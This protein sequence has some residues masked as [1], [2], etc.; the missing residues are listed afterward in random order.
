MYGRRLF[1][2]RPS[3][4]TRHVLSKKRAEYAEAS[5][6]KEKKMHKFCSGR[7]KTGLR[8]VYIYGGLRSER[9]WRT[10]SIR[11]KGKEIIRRALLLCLCAMLAA[12][13]AF[14]EDVEIV[15]LGGE[16]N[17]GLSYGT[18]LADGRSLLIGAANDPGKTESLLTLLCLNPDRTVSW[19]YTDEA[20]GSGTFICAAELSDGTIGAVY[21]RWAEDNTASGQAIRF[22]TPDGKPTGKE[23]VISETDSSMVMFAAKSRLLV[24]VYEDDDIAGWRMIDIDGNEITRMDDSIY[25]IYGLNTI[26]EDDGFVMTAD[27]KRKDRLLSA[28]M[29]VDAGGKVIWKTILPCLWENQDVDSI[30]HVPNIRLAKT[31]D[32]G[33]LGI[34]TEPGPHAI[35]T[36]SALVR[37]D[38]EGRI[39]WTNT[40]IFE[41]MTDSFVDFVVSGGKIAV[42]FEKGGPADFRNIRDFREGITLTTIRA[43]ENGMNPVKSELRIT[44]EDVEWMGQYLRENAGTKKMT[45]QIDTNK[46]IP[47]DDGLWLPA[48]FYVRE[49]QEDPGIWNR[50]STGLIRIPEP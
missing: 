49:Y 50:S 14:A 42:C 37:L 21:T 47:M 13:T 7:Q 2:H 16:R 33:Y 10:M 20:F 31:A 38:S 26:D 24:S 4:Q 25:Y 40:E 28:V 35:G 15:N 12:G 32:G 9:K 8:F 5:P 30:I 43:D 29:K 1:F 11:T 6:E 34:Q 45:P 46:L 44:L 48:V 41:G 18:T 36:K 22:F 39:L 19:E 3:Y 23:T 27:V 17:L